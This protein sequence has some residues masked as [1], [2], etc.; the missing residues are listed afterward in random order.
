MPSGI[1]DNF[2]IDFSKSENLFKNKELRAKLK[3]IAAHYVENGQA[4]VE[5]I[6]FKDMAFALNPVTNSSAYSYAFRFTLETKSGKNL[7]C[8]SVVDKK[9][10]KYSAACHYM[11]K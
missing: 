6:A 5:E 7:L 9:I 4:S 3:E 11:F 10:K 8:I 2:N 1:N